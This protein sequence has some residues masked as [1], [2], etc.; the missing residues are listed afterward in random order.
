MSSIEPHDAGPWDDPLEYSEAELREAERLDE[1]IDDTRKGGLP[2]SWNGIGRLG[3]KFGGLLHSLLAACGWGRPPTRAGFPDPFPGEFQVIRRLGSGAVGDVW[4]ANDL[5]LERKVALKTLRVALGDGGSQNHLSRIRA[6]AQTL[7]QVKHR[8]IVQVF[9]FRCRNGIP[10]L[11]LQ[12]VSGGSLADL[13]NQKGPL[14]WEDAVRYVV[15][16]GEALL[17]VHAR[18][19]FHRDV[20]P[21]NLLIDPDKG[22][23]YLTDFHLTSSQAIGGVAGTPNF[24]APEVFVGHNGAPADVYSLVATL[25]FLLIGESPFRGHDVAEV[26]L[27]SEQGLPDP[28]PRLDHLPEELA[29]TVRRGLDPAPD[30]RPTLAEL[31][32]SLRGGLNRSLAD[33]LASPAASDAAPVDL[34]LTVHR[35]GVGGSESAVASPAATGSIGATRDP[36]GLPP[37]AELLV[38]S[39]GD[40][41]RVEVSAS[42]AG[43]LTVL[44]VGP[45]GDLNYLYPTKPGDAGPPVAVG[46]VIQVA[47]VTAEPPYGR[48]RIFA[49]WTRAI[50]PLEPSEWLSLAE[51]GRAPVSGPYRATRNLV[52]ARD[53]IG[54]L[55]PSDWHA[56]VIALDHRPADG[57]RVEG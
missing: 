25:F 43:Y 9:A 33:S 5:H 16:A 26:R 17:A 32:G 3:H 7:A 19:L 4:L 54:S 13:V 42:S 29:A 44:N 45:S 14:A 47:D 11:V 1:W 6:E 27:K 10:Y 28:D 56:V 12:Y 36:K 38:V 23:V 8:N 48:E 50:W 35:E 55:K 34:K 18:G 31:I 39:T 51:H 21:G 24:M 46:E 15:D 53:R 49:V 40:R 20:K 52:R 2:S 22:E 37:S 30:R 57:S 41:L